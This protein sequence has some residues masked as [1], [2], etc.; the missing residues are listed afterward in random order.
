MRAFNLSE[1]Y[2]VPVVLLIDEINAHMREKV[3]IPENPE[4]INRKKPTVDPDNFMPYDTGFGDVPPMA[5]YGEGYRFHVTGLMHDATGFPSGD[6]KVV[7]Q[8]QER[9]QR[10]IESNV[11]KITSF[12]GRQLSDAQTV[13]VSFGSTARAVSHAVEELRAEG[14]KVGSFRP[15][16]LHPFPVADL[17]A[18]LADK[19]VKNIV[20]AEMNLGQ[21]RLEIERFVC[22]KAPVFGL[23]KVDGEPIVPEEVAA[24][25]REVLR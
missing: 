6:P 1:E 13:I 5:N 24:R 9:L 22:S 10:K 2:R 3:E 21:L 8:T 23:H 18:L 20:V 16:T 4:V 11:G 25:V 19:K 15:L 12:Q 14:I 7:R 17:N